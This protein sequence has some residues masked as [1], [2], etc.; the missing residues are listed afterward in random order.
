LND[1]SQLETKPLGANWEL[2]L[3]KLWPLYEKRFH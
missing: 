2:K 3:I 1:K